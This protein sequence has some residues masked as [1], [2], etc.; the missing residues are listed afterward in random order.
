MPNRVGPVLS[1]SHQKKVA[2]HHAFNGR[3]PLVIWDREVPTTSS[4]WTAKGAHGYAMIDASTPLYRCLPDTVA[5]EAKGEP[6][7]VRSSRNNRY[8]HGAR[9]GGREGRTKQIGVGW[10]FLE[11]HYRREAAASAKACGGAAA[12]AGVSV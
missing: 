4:I 12:A 5:K 8:D 6:R 7:S 9:I 2:G 3:L 11:N 1:M 10:K